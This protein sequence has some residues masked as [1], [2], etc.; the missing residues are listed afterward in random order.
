MKL[1][2]YLIKHGSLNPK[3]VR[4]MKIRNTT[5]LK[6]LSKDEI[7]QTIELIKSKQRARFKNRNESKPSCVKKYHDEKRRFEEMRAR[8]TMLNLNAQCEGNFYYKNYII[9]VMSDVDRDWSY[10]SKSYGH[11][12]VTVSNRRVEIMNFKKGIQIQI[13]NLNA[14]R[15]NFLK[16]ILMEETK[17]INSIETNMTPGEYWKNYQIRF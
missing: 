9:S 15:G 5:G 17:I 11:P 13:F 8:C 6:K 7:F 1:E 10:Y 2:E 14:F 16:R 3:D 12:K 4:V